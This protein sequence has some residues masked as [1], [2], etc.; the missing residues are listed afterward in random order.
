[1]AADDGTPLGKSI[2]AALNLAGALAA[3]DESFLGFLALRA[4]LG[5]AFPESSGASN[6]WIMAWFRMGGNFSL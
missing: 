5:E 3:P 1:M 4:G 6:G 2:V